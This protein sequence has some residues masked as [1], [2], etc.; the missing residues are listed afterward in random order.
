MK[1]AILGAGISGLT[2][3]HHLQKQ[4]H[5]VV[6]FEARSRIGG[7][8]HTR[9]I[10]GC[11]VEWGPNGFLDNEPATLELVGELGLN[12]R[13]QPARHEAARRFVWRQGE[14]RLLPSRPQDF[15][16]TDCLPLLQRLR[17]LLEPW[18]PKAPEGDESVYDFAR[19]RLGR[20]A[21]DILVDA[22]ATGIFAGD[23]RRLSLRSAF[24]RLHAM[25][26]EHGSLLKAARHGR[27]RAN[28][29]STEPGPK[30]TL[31]SF[32]GGLQVLIDALAQRL[33]VRLEQP[34]TSLPKGFDHVLVTTPAHRAAELFDDPL[35]DRLRRIHFAPL[36]VVALAFADDLPVDDAFGFLV[37]RGQDIRLLG[38]L[39][40]SSIFPHRAPDGRRLF[41]V[42]IGGRHDPEI[43]ELSD[44]EVLAEVARD[45]RRIW[46]VFP[47]PVMHHII[48]YGKG[49]AQFELGHRR[50]VEEIEAHCPPNV[51]LAGSSYHGVALNACVAE[52]RRWSP[53]PAT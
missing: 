21:A 27:R 18:A 4:G 34:L 2:A 22:F 48:R 23:V 11:T 9:I 49:I 35:A 17:A 44:D 46:G 51:R 47:D 20:G 38:T 3:A 12:D 28:V 7:N 36:V 19:R 52:A 33:D 5:D 15:L 1:I 29:D 41:R 24:P 10:D 26:A 42:L 30:S 31:Y 45:L 14:L 16:T 43:Q 50:L 40:S 39:Y 8:I 13:L 25:E 6:V 32:D 53:M 37:P